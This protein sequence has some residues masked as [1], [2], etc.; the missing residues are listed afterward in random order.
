MVRRSLVK[1][2][3]SSTDKQYELFITDTNLLDHISKHK[4]NSIAAKLPMIEQAIPYDVKSDGAYLL[5]E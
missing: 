3:T 4:I 5:N 1:T 2:L